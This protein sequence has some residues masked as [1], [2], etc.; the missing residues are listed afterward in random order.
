MGIILRNQAQKANIS[1]L[2]FR[3]NKLK[4]GLGW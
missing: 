1:K 4:D 3:K 2:E